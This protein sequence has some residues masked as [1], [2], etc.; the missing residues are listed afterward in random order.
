MNGSLRRGA[1]FDAAVD[2]LVAAGA[3]AIVL[4]VHL[5]TIYPGLV[6][7]GDA[8]K[9]SFVGR[10][11]GTPH[12]PGY[13]L[14]VMVSHVYSY[15]PWG[16]LAYRMNALSAI[17]GA[18]AVAMTYVV[19]R[20]L[21]AGRLVACVVA[22]ALGFGQSFWAISL[23]A[24]T[25]TLH[26]FLVA[27]GVGLLLRWSVRR[28]VTAFLSAVGVFALAA[29]NHLTVIGLVPALVIFSVVTDHRAVLRPKVLL[30]SAAIVFAGLCQYLLILI[31]THQ[32]APYLEARARTLGELWAVMTAR[33]FAREVG[34]FSIGQLAHTRIPIVAGLIG[35]ELGVAGLVFLAI[36]LAVLA[37]LQPRRA[38]LL[39]LGAFGVAML[40]ADMG[41]GEDR[42]FL[43]A[44]FV[45]C[46]MIV[47]VGL[48][49]AVTAA[50]SRSRALGT[51][52]LVVAAAIPIAQVAANYHVNDHHAETAETEYFDA[53]FA[54]MPDRSAF[55]SDEYR[56]NMLFLYKLLGERA[57]GTRDIRYTRADRA[58]LQF[59]HNQ[60]FQLFALGQA[61]DQFSEYGFGFAPYAATAPQHAA[62]LG[63]HGLYRA[64]VLPSCDE[65]GNLGWTDIINAARPLGRLTVRID[66]YR[67]FEARLVTYDAAESAWTPAVAGA[68][69][70]GVPSLVYD[71]FAR[72]DTTAQ[73]RMAARLREDGATMS[74]Q[75][76]VAPFVVRTETRVND[77]GQFATY[78]LDLGPVR[79]VIAS[80]L[81]DQDT[82]RRATVCSHPF[83]DINVWPQPGGE[84]VE[85]PPDSSLIS[86]EQ[87]W[88]PVERRDDGLKSR[89]SGAQARLVV[90]IASP[91]PARFVIN[92][93]PLGGE[94]PAGSTLTLV[95]N[96]HRLATHPL[97]PLRSGQEWHL[98]PDV[99]RGGLNEFDL[100]IT[101]AAR[102]A[103]LGGSDDRRVLGV[104]VTSF[105]FR[106]EST[107]TR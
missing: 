34:A 93:A 96:G 19:A 18:A 91:V 62:A 1:R 3:A 21:G 15:L 84:G 52:A 101:G 57:N 41:S 94:R 7:I 69:G 97:P 55:V 42:G 99:M 70:F 2:L 20:Q 92:A 39:G 61:R 26:A 22:L 24:K 107:V 44:V 6:D 27:V 53:L 16:T 95:V 45:L 4:S 73:A 49:W 82:P 75:L 54:E 60:G 71:V 98:G 8:A 88:Y 86:F 103:D 35:T 74:E 10:V 51:V 58:T 17:F 13:P 46:W 11:L 28:T 48:Q 102:P 59:L 5:T 87:G 38:L 77:R 37:R 85:L 56:Y 40:T 67:P 78:G 66:N 32:R 100:E 89:W 33:R 76:R 81:V 105:E 79:A 63:L 80:A 90:P 64:T 50:A 14:Y 104:S 25:Y 47:A 72:D 68:K 83:A 65:I 9:F 106:P 31:R 30:A 29:G 12:A 36:G 43:L 23:Y